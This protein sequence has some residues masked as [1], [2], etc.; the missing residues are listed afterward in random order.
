MCMW[1]LQHPLAGGSMTQNNPAK[2]IATVKVI[3]YGPG[4]SGKTTNLMNSHDSH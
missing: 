2:R 3:Y 1:E 4:L